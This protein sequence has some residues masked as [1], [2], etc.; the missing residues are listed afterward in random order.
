LLTLAVIA[1]SLIIVTVYRFSRAFCRA[2]EEASKVGPLD[3]H[4]VLGAP[5]RI[6]PRVDFGS[7]LCDKTGS[8]SRLIGGTES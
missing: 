8:F 4:D 7:L 3:W 2:T 1:V 6:G 5:R